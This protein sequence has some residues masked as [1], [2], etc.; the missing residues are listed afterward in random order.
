MA[1]N[2]TITEV[3]EANHN[4]SE[5]EKELLRWHYRLGHISFRKIQFLFRSGILSMY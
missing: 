2:T 3:H 1:M 5:P 4:L